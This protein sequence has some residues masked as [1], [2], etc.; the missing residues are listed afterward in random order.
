MCAV[1]SGCF[2]GCSSEFV[3]AGNILYTQCC[4]DRM[5]LPNLPRLL[6]LTFRM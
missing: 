5:C 3:G 4:H 6:V 2:I 1:D